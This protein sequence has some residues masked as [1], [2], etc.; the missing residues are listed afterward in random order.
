[1]FQLQ[2]LR[3]V[4]FPSD[5]AS[6][7][8][9]Q[10]FAVL[11]DEVPDRSASVKVPTPQQPYQSMAGGDVGEYAVEIHKQFGRI[12]M[13]IRPVQPAVGSSDLQLMN[14]KNSLEFTRNALM[15][16]SVAALE[17]NRLSVIAV[18]AKKVSSVDEGRIE[19]SNYTKCKFEI[20]GLSDLFLQINRR[21]EIGGHI[22]NRVLQVAVVSTQSV[23]LEFGMAGMQQNVVNEVHSLLVTHDFNTAAHGV[24]FRGSV[25]QDTFIALL[26][27]IE[28][29]ISFGGIDFLGDQN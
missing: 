9:S 16:A 18:A 8:P 4:W 6:G 5:P 14:V 10:I 1:M 29:S 27:D 11:F 17:C 20:D 26:T 3:V 23:S 28:R 21:K 7:D 25:Q 15:K 22:C 24:I 2:E 13:F 19:W 12:D